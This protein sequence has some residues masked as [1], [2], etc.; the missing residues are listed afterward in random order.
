[1]SELCETIVGPSCANTNPL[2]TL[3]PSIPD[4]DPGH[5]GGRGRGT[6]FPNRGRRG[7]VVPPA[8]RGL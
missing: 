1:M 5:V 8:P 7:T 3:A 6:P 2:S 4:P